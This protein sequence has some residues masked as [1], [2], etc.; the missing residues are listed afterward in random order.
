MAQFQTP[1]WMETG[2]RRKGEGSTGAEKDHKQ[3][4]KGGGRGSSSSHLAALENLVVHTAELS[5]ET[6]GEA[7]EA[8]GLLEHAALLP[9]EGAIMAASLEEGRAFAKEREERKG[10]NIGPSHVRIALKALQALLEMDIADEPLKKAAD[11]FWKEKVL[12]LSPDLLREEIQ[13]FKAFNPKVKAKRVKAGGEAVNYGEEGYGRLVFRF[14]PATPLDSVA[15]LFEAEFVR[16]LRDQGW[17]VLFG[18]PP[19]SKKERDLS[20]ALQ[21]FKKSR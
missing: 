20:D 10:E 16:V 17:E 14:K 2:N 3:A 9:S 7:R 11:L 15:A 18:T 8:I 6:K 13:I 21:N 4:R 1:A 12:K 5:L 19:R